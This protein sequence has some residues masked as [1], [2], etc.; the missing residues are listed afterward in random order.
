MPCC[1]AI[2]HSKRFSPAKRAL[3]EPPPPSE[4]LAAMA[5]TS[6]SVGSYSYSSASTNCVIANILVLRDWGEA[7]EAGLG[8]VSILSISLEFLSLFSCASRGKPR[9]NAT[10]MAWRRSNAL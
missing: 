9:F 8:G 3:F 1:T 2:L 10:H 7:E 4:S 6:V 5:G